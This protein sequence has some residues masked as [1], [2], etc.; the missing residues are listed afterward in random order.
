MPADTVAGL[1][2]GP[3]LRFV[4]NGR[5]SEL[6]GTGQK[7]GAVIDGQRHCLF[8]GQDKLRLGRLIFDE[9]AGR[10]GRE[11]FADVALVGAC[12]LRELARSERAGAG[13]FLVARRGKDGPDSPSIPGK[14]ER[15]PYNSPPA[16]RKIAA[17]SQDMRLVSS[18]GNRGGDDWCNWD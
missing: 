17:A 12:L 6:K 10:L 14:R 3:E 15:L 1:E 5:G 16:L 2:G 13:Q 9:A 7:T 4:R 8:L 18:L 11:P